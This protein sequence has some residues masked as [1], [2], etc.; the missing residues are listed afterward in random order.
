MT[1]SPSLILPEI[2]IPGV[3][4]G[5][6]TR[7]GGVSEAPFDALNLGDHVGDNPAH[8]RENRARLQSVLPEQPICWLRQ[9]H[10]NRTVL[11]DHTDCSEAD[12]HWTAQ[13]R[14]PLAILTA[15]CLP[16]V[17][18]AK[19]ASCVGIAHAGW[20]GLSNGI[21][22]SLLTTLPLAPAQLFAW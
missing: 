12:A 2:D 5:V 17:I 21:L 9:V 15:D 18:A 20:R 7:D 4:I 16:V 11:A 1:P 13:R 19:D 3:I 10:G 8:V 22:E 6:T 14:T